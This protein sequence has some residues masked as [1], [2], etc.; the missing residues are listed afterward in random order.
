MTNLFYI[1]TLKL[2]SYLDCEYYLEIFV[3]VYILEKQT[4]YSY[5]ESGKKL[6]F[7]DLWSEGGKIQLKVRD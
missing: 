7:I 5:R 1:K 6:K 3:E 4:F 2:K